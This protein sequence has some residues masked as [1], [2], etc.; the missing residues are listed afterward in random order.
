M[1]RRK[2]GIFFIFMLLALLCV[3]EKTYAMNAFRHRFQQ[4]KQNFSWKKAA[5]VGFA[6]GCTLA[7][8]SLA[9]DMYQELVHLKKIGFNDLLREQ[10]YEKLPD[11]DPLIESFVR[12]Q[13]K[14]CSLTDQISLKVKQVDRHGWAAC[15]TKN[16]NWIFVP[17]EDVDAFKTI[18]KCQNNPDHLKAVIASIHHECSH[19]TNRDHQKRKIAALGIPVAV[20]TLSFGIR[21][22]LIPTNRYWLNNVSKIVNG[23]A[24]LGTVSAGGYYQYMQFQELKADDN[25]QDNF[26]LLK[27]RKKW[28]K[29]EL[30][31]HKDFY[32]KK[33]VWLS[34]HPH[35]KVRIRRLKKRIK[36]LKETG[37]SKAFEDPLATKEEA[38]IK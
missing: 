6:G 9:Y 23:I 34:D 36:A 35:P 29:D 8:Y 33:S 30:S 21:K 25:I 27:T 7:Q 18:L 2:L 5:A 24:V 15:D 3:P 11:V 14:K 32:G 12:E 19:I 38:Q 20:S 1:F 31:N 22:K 10:Y 37:D 4:V 26:H 17:S 16:Y 13:T 28:M